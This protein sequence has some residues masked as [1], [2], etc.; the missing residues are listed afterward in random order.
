[1]GRYTANAGAQIATRTAEFESQLCIGSLPA[2]AD[3][4][5]SISQE[6]TMLDADRCWQAI[7]ERDSS[8][9][10]QFVF[11]V[12]TTGIYCRPGCPARRPLRRNVSF[13]ADA[14]GAAAAGFRACRRCSPQGQSAEAMLDQL[15]A[16]VSRLLQHSAE[17][18][19]LAQLAAHS[20]YSASHLVRAFK[21]RTGLTPRAWAMARRRQ[22]ENETPTQ[23][24]QLR[25]TVSACP[26]GYVLL[27]ASG[28]GVAALLFG[29]SPQQLEQALA[30]RF[31]KA[32]CEPDQTGLRDWLQQ[33]LGQLQ[34]P[35]RAAHL[36]LDLQGTAFQQRVWQALQKIPAGQ[37]CSY[38][39]LAVALDSH[40]RA[41]ASACAGNPVGLLVP[42]H[43]VIGS[44]GAL[45][46]YRWGLQRKAALLEGERLAALNAQ[47]VVRSD[48]E[49]CLSS[50]E[51]R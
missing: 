32:R 24:R 48:A 5:T 34:E 23:H 47:P 46:G 17:I 18:P 3:N 30:K 29:D 33:V 26:L 38:R 43:R 11:A 28:K 6:P 2:Q 37:A 22:L 44:N 40:P 35:A 1:L 4:P 27:A 21:L 13:F 41:V 36:P 7:C 39:Q 9:D 8:L 16:Q 15:V 25:Y 12:H 42:C 14:A 51:R 50:D 19:T 20:G 45:S 31:S 10:G 49:S